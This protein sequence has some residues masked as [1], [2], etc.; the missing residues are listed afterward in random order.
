[1]LAVG[2]YNQTHH[3]HM[4]FSMCFQGEC[5]SVCACSGDRLLSYDTHLGEKLGGGSCKVLFLGLPVIMPERE[6]R[7]KSYLFLL[8]CY[9]FSAYLM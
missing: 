6:T 3:F 2:V 4:V 7:T 8:L 9:L 1:M 5:A